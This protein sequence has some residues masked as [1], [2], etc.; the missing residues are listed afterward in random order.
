MVAGQYRYYAN[1]KP[2]LVENKEITMDICVNLLVCSEKT[3]V[4]K[5]R[6]NSVMCHSNNLPS[7]S[8]HTRKTMETDSGCKVLSLDSGRSES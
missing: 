5:F 3:Y 6:S 7:K 4:G 8:W 2:S 1:A